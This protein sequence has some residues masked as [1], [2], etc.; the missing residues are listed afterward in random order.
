ME[1]LKVTQIVP[2]EKQPR[3]Y[4]AADKMNKLRNSIEREGIINPLVVEEI[5]KDKYLLIDGERR[6]RCAVELGLKEVPVVIEPQREYKD[7]LLRQFA[8][9]EMHEGWTPL[10]KAVALDNLS[11]E[12]GVDLHE[13]CKII[14]ATKDETKKYVAFAQI[15]GKSNFLKNEIP[16]D[17]A[18]GIRSLTNLAKKLTETELEEKFDKTDIARLERRVVELIK[19]G[20][21][22]LRED[23]A[24]LKDAFVKEPKLIEKFME[25]KTT[26]PQSLFLE[27]KGQGAYHI[28]NVMNHIGYATSHAKKFILLKDVELTQEQLSRLRE[29]RDT[30]EALISL[31]E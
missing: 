26:T 23:I 17:W 14:G 7:R 6:F 18:M 16:L 29:G 27:S 9:Q 11:Q 22:T 5:G 21:L 30:L 12:L 13:V 20:D 25:D 10:E 24:R 1:K 3:N 19:N 28:R 8:M 2:D 31:A 15:V 4:F